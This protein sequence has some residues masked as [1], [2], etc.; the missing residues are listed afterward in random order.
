MS[1]QNQGYEII[2]AE[3]YA[4]ENTGRQHQIVLGRMETKYGTTYVTW[5]SSAMENSE[6]ADYFWGHY[7]DTEKAARIDYHRRL[8]SHYER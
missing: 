1:E 5:E 3:T 8:L 7:H 2:A 6:Y 4:T